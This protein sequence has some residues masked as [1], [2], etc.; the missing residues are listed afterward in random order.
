[1]GTSSRHA[2]I[3]VSLTDLE[4]LIR[5]VVHEAVREELR[6]LLRP[7]SAT[8][9]DYWVHEGPEDPAGDADLLA[10]ALQVI[11]EHEAVAEGWLS[12]EEFERT[13]A[14]PEAGSESP[15]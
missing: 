13:A 10:E 7:S 2:T 6:R 3:T 9:A 14:T 12:L 15:D 8:A 11:E 5:R 1:M 4:A